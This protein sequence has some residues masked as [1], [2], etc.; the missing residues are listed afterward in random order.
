VQSF[1]FEPA[2]YWE[3]TMLKTK[4]K[5]VPNR[6]GNDGNDH[7]SRNSDVATCFDDFFE[8]FNVIKKTHGEA[9]ATRFVR[10]VTGMG[11][12]DEEKG[13]TEPPL[14]FTQRRIHE[15]FCLERGWKV[16]SK[17]VGAYHPLASYDQRPFDEDDWPEQS[18]ALPV[19]YWASFLKIWKDNSPLM[20]IRAPSCDVCGEC[21]IYKNAFRYKTSLVSEDPEDEG[22]EAA[23]KE[24][25]EDD[26]FQQLLCPATRQKSHL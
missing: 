1:L 22:D 4:L 9:N 17:N 25:E 11:L 21:Y 12:R 14:H 19:C 7:R 10:E 23:L 6:H 15:I 16:M 3:Y 8:H 5:L 24:Q 18:E 2:V 20:R 13:V 26:E